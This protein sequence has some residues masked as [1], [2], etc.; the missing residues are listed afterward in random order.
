[1][2]CVSQEYVPFFEAALDGMD[3]TSLRLFGA[4]LDR[5]LSHRLRSS[6]LPY[7][8]RLDAVIPG[9]RSDFAQR[10]LTHYAVSIGIQGTL[11]ED[12]RAVEHALAGV[13]RP[14]SPPRRQQLNDDALRAVIRELLPEIGMRRTPMLRHLR[15]KRGLACEQERFRRLFEQVTRA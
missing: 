7:D 2:A 14:M 9:L 5:V 3:A 4:G 11:E 13:Q 1:L 8:D 12:H 6:L 10:A 15:D